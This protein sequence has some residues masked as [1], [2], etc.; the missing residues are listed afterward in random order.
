MGDAGTPQ[1]GGEPSDVRAAEHALRR[2]GYDRVRPGS[3]EAGPSAFWVRD[4]G[5][6]TRLLRVA[7]GTAG[8]P[9]GP[10]DA[11]DPSI[12]VVPTGDAAEAAWTEIRRRGAHRA[13]IGVRILI[14]GGRGN[15]SPRWHLARMERSELLTLATGTL[16]G[17]LR[18]AARN[19]E[20]IPIDFEEMLE[21]LRRTFHVD[22]AGTLGV[23]SDEDALWVLYQMAHRYSYAPGDP[24]P[25]LHMLVLK[26]SGPAARLPWFAA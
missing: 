15:D 1:V 23:K 26:P 24:G 11:S 10:L 17:H 9:A 18:R 22:V 7:V 6:A 20:S 14:L 25:N 5:N 8:L 16:V 12:V 2:L 13:S 19:E 4:R 3:P 21:T